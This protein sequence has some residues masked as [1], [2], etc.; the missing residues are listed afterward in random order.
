[1][2]RSDLHI[3]L[4]GGLITLT[5]GFNIEVSHRIKEEYENGRDYYAFHGK[6]L[7]HLAS[8]LGDGTFPEFIGLA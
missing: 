6:R 2:L 3:L 8:R 7:I 5:K 4:D 1:M